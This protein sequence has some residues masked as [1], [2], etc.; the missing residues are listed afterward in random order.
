MARAVAT[1]CVAVAGI[2]TSMNR[3]MTASESK[4]KILAVLDDV[5][6]EDEVEIT[7]EG[8]IVAKL[9][10][11]SGAKAVKEGLT[12]SRR[13]APATKGRSAAERG[14]CGDRCARVR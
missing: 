5:A 2:V 10:P 7:K 14:A 12:A 13:V 4:A 6:A 1:L 8:G 3:K 9:V 11:A